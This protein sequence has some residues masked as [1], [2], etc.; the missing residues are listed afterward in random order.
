MGDL[1]RKNLKQNYDSVMY[2]KGKKSPKWGTG[3][4][5]PGGPGVVNSFIT[6]ILIHLTSKYNL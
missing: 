4:K 5:D 2:N 6:K 3:G 1:K